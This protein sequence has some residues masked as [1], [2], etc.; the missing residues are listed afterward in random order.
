MFQRIV[1]PIYIIILSLISS[2]VIVKPKVEF[3][4]NYLKFILF[5]LGFFLILFS[6]LSYKFIYFSRNVEVVFILL[7]IIFIFIF[8]LILFVKTKFKLKYL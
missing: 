1:N 7:P 4:G 3:F 2:L 8:Y 6:Q 5:I